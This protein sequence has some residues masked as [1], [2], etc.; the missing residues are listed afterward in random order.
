MTPL[1]YAILHHTGIPQPHFDLLFETLPGSEL[2]AWR[3][4]VWPI[5][6]NTPL[7]RLRDH[8][9]VYLEFEGELTRGRGS[10]SRVARGTC[11]V[12]VGEDSVWTISLL[13]GSTP[14]TL[15]LKYVEAERWEASVH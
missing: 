9:R 4:P 7:T 15:R 8:R 11:A 1:Q 2:A 3:S 13:T 14:M 10:V 6:T 12:E 5:E